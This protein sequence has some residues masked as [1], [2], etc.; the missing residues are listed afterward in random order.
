MSE[1]SRQ[2][3]QLTTMMR[4]VSNEVTEKVHDVRWKIL[5][6]RWWNRSAARYRKLDQINHSTATARERAQ[7][8]RLLYGAAADGFR[9][10]DTV[11]RADHL[12]PHAASI[13]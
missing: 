8:L 2:H 1:L 6:R 9:D 10:Y 11:A 12:D 7:Q 13:V 4:L 5:P 3:A